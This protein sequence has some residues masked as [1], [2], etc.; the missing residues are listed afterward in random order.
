ML[1]IFLLK[2]TGAILFKC[3]TPNLTSWIRPCL[4]YYYYAVATFCFVNF[5]LMLTEREAVN[6]V[7]HTLCVIFSHA[8]I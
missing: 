4:R 3:A 1:L 2:Y 7:L 6:C 8:E 5:S